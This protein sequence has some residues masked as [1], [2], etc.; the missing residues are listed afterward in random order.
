M[1]G[2]ARSLF[3]FLLTITVVSAAAGAPLSVQLS[4]DAVT[5]LDVTPGSS[6]A[7]L[8]VAREPSYYMSRV[9]SRGE[10]LIDTDRDGTVR[11]EAQG[12]VA[13]SSIWVVVDVRSGDIAWTVPAGFL[14]QEMR[15][16]GAGRGRALEAIAGTVETGRNSVDLMIVR[17]G[18]GAWSVAARDGGPSDRDRTVN[19]RVRLDLSKLTPLSPTSGAAP[20]ALLKGDVVVVLDADLMEYAFFTVPEATP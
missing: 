1:K 9:V 20:H 10:M 16:R 7:M 4:N 13:F 18:T 3:G 8:S 6:V 17:P 11:Y 15:Q 19:G 5:V 12:G 2:T 14:A